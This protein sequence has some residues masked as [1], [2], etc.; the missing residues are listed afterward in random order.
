MCIL[1]FCRYH[2]SFS[3]WQHSFRRIRIAGRDV[4]WKSLLSQTTD[5]SLMWLVNKCMM[6]SSNG[7][8]FR[9]TSPL[10]GTPLVTGGFSSQRPVTRSFDVFFELRLNKRLSK[11]SRRRWFEPPW[12][13]IWR[14]CHGYLKWVLEIFWNDLARFNTLRPR[15]NVHHFADGIFKMP[16]SCMKVIV[17]CFKIHWQL[18]AGVL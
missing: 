12:R 18:F 11:Q 10:W 2:D 14:H 7:N 3:Q 8:I 17:F 16:L 13:S 9:V 15:P 6:A 4:A 5:V 1:T